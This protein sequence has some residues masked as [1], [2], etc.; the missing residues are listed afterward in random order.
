MHVLII[1]GGIGG[2]AI[3]LS[4]HAASIP[5]TVFEQVQERVPKVLEKEALNQFV[6]GLAAAPMSERDL[7][8]FDLSLS[9]PRS[10]YAF[11]QRRG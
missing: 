10:F 6:H 4:L 8:V 11:E 9:A 5:C 2:L 3:A 1:G 7:S